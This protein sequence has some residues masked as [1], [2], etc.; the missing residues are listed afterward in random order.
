MKFRPNGRGVA[1]GKAAE[2]DDLFE[3]AEDWAVKS[4]GI[5]DLIYPVGSLYLSVGSTSPAV[6]FGGTW[7]QIKD[8]FLLSAGDVYAAGSTGGA[9]SHDHTT[10]NCT[11]NINQIPSHA[12]GIH[13]YQ[14]SAKGNSVVWGG[15]STTSGHTTL[16]GGPA[17][18]NANGGGQAHNHGKT[19]AAD[20]MPPYLAVYIWKR[21][22]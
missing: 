7:E 15:N 14:S 17:A 5:V 4:R 18:V 11:L 16:S 13:I 12:H 10:G 21:T 19:G 9:A 1:F 8:R 3:I 6:L 20:S 22:A 2:T